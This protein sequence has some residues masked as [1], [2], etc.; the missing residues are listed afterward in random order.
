[1]HHG[2]EADWFLNGRQEYR[3]RRGCSEKPIDEGCLEG[4]ASNDQ[5]LYKDCTKTCSESFCNNDFD[6]VAEMFSTGRDLTCYSCKY[7][8]YF[9]GAVSGNK[10]CGDNP[11]LIPGTQPKCPV[12]ADAGCFTGTNAQY[13]SEM[14][15]IE[16]VYK[17]C[18][19]FAYPSPKC[20]VILGINVP[21]Q[22]E[23]GTMGIC[24]EGCSSDLCNKEHTT[25][26][27]P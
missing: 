6:S 16:E 27:V 9:D 7:L 17:G 5:M 12:F 23:P 22:D 8:E 15:L 14:T 3:I 18:S 19:S 26:E 13:N 21:G 24:K 11:E 20:D 25:P 10:N 2:F 4:S 1:L